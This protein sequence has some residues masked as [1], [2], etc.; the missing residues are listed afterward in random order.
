MQ[1]RAHVGGPCRTSETYSTSMHFEDDIFKHVVLICLVTIVAECGGH[2]R[3]VKA[4][5]WEGLP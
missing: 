5:G 1:V 2:W 4:M 3:G